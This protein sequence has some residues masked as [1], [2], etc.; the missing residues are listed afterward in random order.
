[1]YHEKSV[2]SQEVIR[3]YQGLYMLERREIQC[4]SMIQTGGTI[5]VILKT[6]S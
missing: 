2:G 4:E 6:G 5:P 1:M 3:P